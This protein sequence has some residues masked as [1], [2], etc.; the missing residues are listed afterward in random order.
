ME[1]T[2]ITILRVALDEI[3][4]LTPKQFYIIEDYNRKEIRSYGS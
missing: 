3:G 2:K 1:S 4:T